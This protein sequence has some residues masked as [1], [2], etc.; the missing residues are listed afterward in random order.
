MCRFCTL[1]ETA[2]KILKEGAPWANLAEL[3]TGLLK[4]SIGKDLKESNCLLNLW[5]YCVKH[6]AWINNLTSKD[7]FK[8]QG[9][10]P[11]IVTIEEMVDIS[12][13]Y[14]FGWYE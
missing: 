11:F 3:C 14:Q 8:L 12:N 4:S 9:S 7:S 5:D 1:I 13:I 10:S 2:L 6:H